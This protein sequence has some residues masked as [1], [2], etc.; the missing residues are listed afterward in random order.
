MPTQVRV[1]NFLGAN[2]PEAAQRTLRVGFVLGGITAAASA[3]SVYLFQAPIIAIFTPDAAIEAEMSS[4]LP[5]FCLAVFISGLH[6]IL[7]AVVEAMSLARTL[8]TITL[9]GSWL[10]TL[11]MV[12]LLGI[13]L[14]G[15]LRGL[16]WGSVMGESVKFTLM[17]TVLYRIDWAEMA[18]RAVK[19]SEGETLMDKSEM[20]EDVALLSAVMV[21]STPT[22]GGVSPVLTTL[23][24]PLGHHHPHHPTFTDH[25]EG[26]GA[27]SATLD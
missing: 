18:R 20:E 8:V 6:I 15:G 23:T 7:A 2:K 16:W 14:H 10:V 19:Q 11:P 27:T 13:A 24:T 5:V 9:S 22:M 3:L 17:A 25:E 21:A 12:Y 4:V 1:A 26:Y